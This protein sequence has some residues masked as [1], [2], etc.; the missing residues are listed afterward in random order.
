M[1]L[2]SEAKPLGTPVTSSF[3]CT[4]VLDP[5]DGFHQH[6]I[7]AVE[8]LAQVIVGD[9]EKLA[10][11]IIEQVEDIGAV[12]IGVANDLATDPDEFALDEFL[13]NILECA[14]ILAEE[15]TAVGEAG[16]IIG[17][18]NNDQVLRGI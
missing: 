10:F 12:F 5:L 1:T 9:L 14:S 3:R 17:A 7:D 2:S 11:G 4:H 18:A 6:R 16:N 15:I 8:V 13:Q